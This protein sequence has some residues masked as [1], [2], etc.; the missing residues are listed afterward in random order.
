MGFLSAR[1]YNFRN[2]KNC[3]LNLEA[4][5]V[6]LIGENGQGKT[7]FIESIYLL[8][9]GA[10]FR[11]KLDKRLIN[12]QEEQS[13]VQG[14]FSG[15]GE[16][17]RE[18][19]VQI[20]RNG[21]KEIRV[22]SKLIQDRK[23]LIENIPCIV[24]SHQDMDF[25]TGSPEKRRRFF[26]QTLSLF[27]PFFIDLMRRYRRILKARN[28][29]LKDKKLNL[30]ETF[31]QNLAQIGLQIQ[32][33]REKIAT[34]FNHTFVPVFQ[35]I[36]EPNGNIRI[37]YKPSWRRDAS[38]TE[39]VSHLE[40]HMEQDLR[41]ETSTSGPHRDNFMIHQDGKDFVHIASTGQIR[42]SSLILKVAQARFFSSKTGRLPILL[43]DD[44]LLE[45]DLHRRE[46]FLKTLPFYVQAFFTFLPD[47]PFL[48][49][50]GKNTLIYNVKGGEFIYTGKADH[51]KSG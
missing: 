19:A 33:K 8:C 43:L 24:F 23:D 28:V 35:S 17:R 22:D 5:E 7:N 12:N 39:I 50:C 25:I 11:T 4:P 34:D 49:Y 13:A 45:L 16:P 42:L 48:K 41:F 32:E 3:A 21:K 15:V 37:V 26:N 1:Y 31:N 10:S 51:E 18:I 38:V 47:E 40:K 2:I 9:F 20:S 29:L 14:T 30:L 36:S 27:D 44:V 46:N 6:F